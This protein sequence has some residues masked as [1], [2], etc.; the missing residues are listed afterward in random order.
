MQPEWHGEIVQLSWSPRAY[1]LK[2]FLSDE[3]VDHIITTATPKMTKS[4]VVDGKT[5]GNIPSSIRTSTGCFF[6]QGRDAIVSRV[7]ARVAQVRP[8]PVETRCQLVLS[9]VLLTATTPVC[10][11]GLLVIARRT[12]FL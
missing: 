12:L 5:G 9:L 6:P 2:G 11:A 8:P 10:R 1:L 4:T 7:E 3:E